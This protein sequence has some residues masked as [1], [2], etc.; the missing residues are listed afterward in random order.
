MPLDGSMFNTA[1]YAATPNTPDVRR[2]RWIDNHPDHL[3]GTWSHYTIRLAATNEYDREE[4]YVPSDANWTMFMG[5][6]EG[7]PT[8]RVTAVMSYFWPTLS[9]AVQYA[10]TYLGVRHYNNPEGFMAF[11]HDT[12]WAPT[13]YGQ[14]LYRVNGDVGLGS[15][16]FVTVG[17]GV[18]TASCSTCGTMAPQNEVQVCGQF[19]VNI[20][21]A[22]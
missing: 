13:Y 11:A 21:N 14:I 1:S 8:E 4:G 6:G 17:P 16:R 10:E 2:Q 18:P 3:V 20:C 5:S 12:G 9:D 7:T 19:V 22:H 15:A